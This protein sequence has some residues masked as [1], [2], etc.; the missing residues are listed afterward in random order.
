MAIHGTSS[1][2]LPKLPSLDSEC[3]V[4]QGNVACADDEK[5][6]DGVSS[7]KQMKCSDL[8]DWFDDVFIVHEDRVSLSV[9]VE[10]EV[11]SFFWKY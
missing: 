4:Q 6:D 10:T 7:A 1:D 9:A 5:L 8:E 3:V 2:V 11:T